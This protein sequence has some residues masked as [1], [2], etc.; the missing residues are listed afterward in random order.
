MTMEHIQRSFNVSL[1]ITHPDLDPEKI[2]KALNLA[3]EQSTRA[4]S[5]RATPTGH[6]LTGTYRFSCWRYRLDTQTA[7]DLCP[8]LESFIEQFQKHKAFFHQ[9]ANEGGTVELFCGIFAAGNWDEVLSH[10]LLG[11][12]AALRVDLR[13]DVYP[14]E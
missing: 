13:L 7:V 8:I 2:S 1:F 10:A 5:P 9:I 11:K 4:G 6:P 12:L 14:K 3:P